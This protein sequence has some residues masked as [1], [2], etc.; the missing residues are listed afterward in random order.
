MVSFQKGL[1]NVAVH[2]LAVQS[3]AKHLVVGTHGRSMYVA[4]IASLQQMTNELTSKETH[5]FSMNDIERT[6]DGEVL[7][8][9]AENLHA[10]YDN[11]FLF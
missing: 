1:P 10:E 8:L 7:E 2:D 4:D 9:R 6:I 5:I 11:S 3:K